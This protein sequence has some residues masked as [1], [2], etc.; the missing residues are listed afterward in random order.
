MDAW[1]W[2]EQRMGFSS[3]R[4]INLLGDANQWCHQKSLMFDPEDKAWGYWWWYNPK[5][6]NWDDWGDDDEQ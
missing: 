3:D 1:L 6:A 2:L 4:I 5:P